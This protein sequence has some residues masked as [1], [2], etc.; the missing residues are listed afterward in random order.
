MKAM[1][2]CAGSGTRLH[3]FTEQTPKTMIPIGGKPLLAH[4][5][6]HLASLG[7]RELLINLCYKP[8][9][10]M[11]Y[12]GDG[13]RWGVKIHYSVETQPLGTAG[14]VK[15][16]QAFFDEGPFLLWYGDNLSH[17][18]VHRLLQFHR[19]HEALF[20]LALHY[21]EDPTSSGIVATD[22]GGRIQRIL[23]KPTPDQVFSHWVSAGIMILEPAVLD[24]IPPDAV[25]DLG[26]HV[27]PSLV[28][29]GE[30]LFAYR[31]SED[32]GLWW[33]DTPAD[34]ERVQSTWA[35][36]RPEP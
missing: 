1:L 20:T 11:A 13:E 8:E 12:F 28:A 34:L 29:R 35:T 21:R 4:T 24:F 6:E 23:E 2:L 36:R 18:R 19:E 25:V 7:I 10:I 26:H 9:V 22:G 33:I 5:I 31:L 27:L 3:P 15:N 30:R 16:V 32:E 14:G 17:C